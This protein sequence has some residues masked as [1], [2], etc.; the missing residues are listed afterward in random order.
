MQLID[1]FSTAPAA[2]FTGVSYPVPVRDRFRFAKRLF[3][4]GRTIG[5]IYADMPQSHSYRRWI[6]ELLRSD[7]EFKGMTVL[8]RMV[9]FVKSEGGHLRMA[10]LAQQHVRE[11]DGQVDLFMSPN[12]QLGAQGP[13][14]EMVFKTATKPLL[15]LGKKNV[16]EGRG[17]VAAISP[18]LQV[19]GQQ[20]AA[21]IKQLLEGKSVRQI[22]PERPA[23]Y[24]IAIDAAK[25]QRFGADL[26]PALIREAGANVLQE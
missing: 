4:K 15:G 7:D 20:A 2:N 8:F 21:M 17:A 25:A 1:N 16:M 12:D 19:M 9:P 6:E 10:L 3:P 11:L 23:A 24:E 5:I 22:I 14:A 18:S 26:S 13:F